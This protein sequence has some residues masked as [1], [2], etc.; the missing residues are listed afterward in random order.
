MQTCPV[1][2]NASGIQGAVQSPEL[3]DRCHDHLLAASLGRHVRADRL[4]CS[5]LSR[6]LGSGI[7][8]FFRDVGTHN[9]GTPSGKEPAGGLADAAARTCDQDHAIG[10]G[11]RRRRRHGG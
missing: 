3:C 1:T 7:R 4:C 10:Q 9:F 11:Q 5:I 8:S 2:L 6:K